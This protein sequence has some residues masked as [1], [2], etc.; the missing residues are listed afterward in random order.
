MNRAVALISIAA[1]FAAGCGRKRTCYGP[2]LAAEDI[3]AADRS[4]A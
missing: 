1:A 2:A 3:T 4:F